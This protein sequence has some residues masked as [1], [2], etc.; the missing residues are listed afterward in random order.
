MKESRGLAPWHG[1]SF[2]P[3]M[4]ALHIGHTT[5]IDRAREAGG[6]VVVSIFVN[7]KQ[8]GPAEDL[9]KYP[10]PIER[11][12]ALCREHGVDAVFVPGVEEMYPPGFVTE[13][14]VP[15]LS[16][17]MCGRSRPGHFTGV[18]TVVTRLFGLVRPRRAL[19][20]W[21]DAQQFLV[22]RRMT[23]D[24]A[25]GVELIPVETV[26][27]ADGLAC[28]SRN[29]YLSPD[30]RR[31]APA[32]QRALQH[33][34]KLAGQGATAAEIVT[35]VELLVEDA[36]MDKDYIDLRALPGLAA[37]V[38]HDVPARFAS[39][40]GFLLAAAV[41]LGTTRLIDNVRFSGGS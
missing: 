2:V 41:R 23:E 26:R 25:L 27:E 30:E 7:P 29:M 36:G 32:L 39:P 12:L 14:T 28:S 3:T 11:D 1:G 8:F 20:G 35:A 24:L 4:G 37:L 34:R 19:F 31:R 21:K 33:G 5:L 18:C 6:P 15:G 38:P 40:G 9:A 22:I 17:V 16:D 13:V 10:R